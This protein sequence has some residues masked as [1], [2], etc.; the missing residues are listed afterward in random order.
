VKNDLRNER[1]G[2]GSISATETGGG[3]ITIV[4]GTGEFYF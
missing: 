2:G 4:D 3:F 1:E